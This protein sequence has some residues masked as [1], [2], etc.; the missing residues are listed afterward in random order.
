[1]CQNCTLYI[2]GW[3]NCIGLLESMAWKGSFGC[4]HRSS[5]FH[6]CC[7]VLLKAITVVSKLF[8]RFLQLS[9]R[10]WEADIHL[11]WSQLAEGPLLVLDLFDFVLLSP[12]QYQQEP[13]NC[14]KSA[15]R[16]RSTQLLFYLTALETWFDFLIMYPCN[17]VLPGCNALLDNHQQSLFGSR[18][19]PFPSWPT[20]VSN[21]R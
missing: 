6:G 12:V 14:G 21:F 3:S 2:S 9:H 8:P 10:Y 5:A 18:N 11:A 20:G 4:F 7:V 16:W 19:R 15:K 17:Y 1:M 13:E